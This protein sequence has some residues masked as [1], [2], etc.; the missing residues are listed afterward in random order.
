MRTFFSG[1]PKQIDAGREA[2]N[3][4]IISAAPIAGSS[5]IKKRPGGRPAAGFFC[6]KGPF[7]FLSSGLAL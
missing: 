3:N 7:C 1:K 2:A 4:G 6:G 5:S